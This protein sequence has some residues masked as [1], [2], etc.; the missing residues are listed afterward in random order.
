MDG[1]TEMIPFEHHYDGDISREEFE[2]IRK[3]LEGAKKTY[4]A[5]YV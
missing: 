2:L 5:S 3:D 4:K 1:E